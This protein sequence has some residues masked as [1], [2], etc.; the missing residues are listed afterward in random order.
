LLRDRGLLAN[1]SAAS[2]VP[3]VRFMATDGR[4]RFARVAAYFLERQISATSVE[5][6]DPGFANVQMTTAV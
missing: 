1:P 2:Q 5:L 4:E 3:N 6:I